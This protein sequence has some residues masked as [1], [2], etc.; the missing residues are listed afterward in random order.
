MAW[1]APL[2]ACAA[3]SGP[4]AHAGC[5]DARTQSAAA[6]RGGGS[7]ARLA[8]AHRRAAC[9]APCIGHPHAVLP[10]APQ[11]GPAPRSWLLHTAV[12]TLV[13]PSAS[14]C[15]VVLSLLC[16]GSTRTAAAAWAALKRRALGRLASDVTRSRLQH[17]SSAPFA[18]PRTRQMSPSSSPLSL[19][20]ASSLQRLASSGEAMVHV[21][22]SL[23][24]SGCGRHR[25][26]AGRQARG[27]AARRHRLTAR[28]RA[29]QRAARCWLQRLVGGLQRA[30]ACAVGWLR[31]GCDGPRR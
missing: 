9:H 5:R 28:C 31:V 13:S 27:R 12:S 20:A 8:R 16:A 2:C 6:V 17:A 19:L 22:Q 24:R 4:M 3:D 10:R 29:I 14:P 25:C 21:K 15:C 1:A 26:A 18:P 30:Q 23:C 11:P 7:G